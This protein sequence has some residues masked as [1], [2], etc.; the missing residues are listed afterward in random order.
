MVQIGA[1]HNES[2]AHLLSETLQK[3]HYPVMV[4]Q[5]GDHLFHVQVGPYADI[6]EAED[7][8][9]RL[10]QSGYNAFVKR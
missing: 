6:H 7:V 4:V 9:N 3:Q 10:Q 2:D 5:P 8:R 1:M